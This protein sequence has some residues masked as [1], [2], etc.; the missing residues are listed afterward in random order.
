[1][2]ALGVHIQRGLADNGSAYR[3]CLFE[4]TCQALGMKKG[5]AA[6]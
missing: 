4:R 6:P 3:S 2:S 1:M 5:A